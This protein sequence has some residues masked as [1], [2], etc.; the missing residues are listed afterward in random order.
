[1]AKE[2]IDST[3][4]ITSSIIKQATEE[5]MTVVVDFKE[6]RG[7]V[8]I[9]GKRY[10]GE[11][12]VEKEIARSLL[13]IM[14]MFRETQKKLTDPSEKIRMKNGFAIEALYLADPLQNVGNPMYHR[15]FGLLDPWQWQFVSVPEK[16]RLKA[17]KVAMFGELL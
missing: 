11:V 5:M 2:V 13:D 8:T 4:D 17:L 10:I 9:N 3:P 15:D 16:A 1:M 6:T 7:G 14:A 12:T